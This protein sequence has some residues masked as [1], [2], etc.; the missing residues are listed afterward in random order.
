MFPYMPAVA[1]FEFALSCFEIYLTVRQKRRF[2]ST[3]PPPELEQVVS[4]KFDKSQKYGNDKCTLSI[5]SDTILSTVHLGFRLGYV[6]P[7]LWKASYHIMVKCAPSLTSSNEIVQTMIFGVVT[8]LL[9]KLIELPFE[10]YGTF[11]LE[12]KYGFNRT[13]LF[14]FFKDMLVSSAVGFGIGIP[15]LPALWY[16]IEKSGPLLWLYFWLFVSGFSIVLTVIYPSGIAPLF[17]TFAPLPDGKLKA[18]IDDLAA[19][20]KFPLT[21]IYVMDGSRRSSHSNAYFYGIFT[22]GIVLFDSLLEQCKGHDERILAVLCHELGH[23]KMGHTRK[24]LILGL[25]QMLFLSWLYG[26]TASNKD[27][28]ESFGYSDTPHLIGMMLFFEIMAPVDSLM[29]LLMNYINRKHEY[30]ADRF[31]ADMGHAEALGDALVGLHLENLSNM[32][33]DPLYSAYHNSHPT[34]LERLRALGVKPRPIPV[35]DSKKDQ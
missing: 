2:Q 5:V 19:S 34:L 24:G 23:W 13:T 20:I 11:V 17:N 7:F 26:Q 10:L 35:S 21:K 6:Y 29:S 8:A 12:E 3:Q 32:N 25:T 22:K 16:I 9:G 27:I 1:A 31:A 28:F 30:E 18:A 4:D 33:P 15:L 14:T